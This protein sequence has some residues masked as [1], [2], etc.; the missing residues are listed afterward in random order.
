M[1]ESQSSSS[2][3][4]EYPDFQEDFITPALPDQVTELT[5]LSDAIHAYAT[6]PSELRAHRRFIVTA[7]PNDIYTDI[8]PAWASAGYHN[9]TTRIGYDIEGN[10][11]ILWRYMGLGQT[12]ATRNRQ[13]RHTTMLT[14]GDSP[15]G[16]SRP[17]ERYFEE[18]G[19][20]E[21]RINF[22]PDKIVERPAHLK[23]PHDLSLGATRGVLNYL[24]RVV[25]DLPAEIRVTVPLRNEFSQL[26]ALDPM[27]HNPGQAAAEIPK[28]SP[29]VRQ[30]SPEQASVE[31]AAQADTSRRN[32][33]RQYL[34]SLF[35]RKREGE[36]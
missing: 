31:T 27:L 20:V 29:R 14:L 28:Q 12:T 10:T 18:D 21:D 4:G 16:F 2:Y 25:A 32:K 7:D 5:E 34:H 30:A 19:H 11:T 15:F 1:S 9:L 23:E 13:V 22:V 8:A 3:S 36:R 26:V 24:R 33:V 6:N 17:T 35:R